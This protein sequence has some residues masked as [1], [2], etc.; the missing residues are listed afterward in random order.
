MSDSKTGTPLPAQAGE[1]PPMYPQQSHPQH[2]YPPQQPELY[3]Q[4]SYPQQPYPQQPYP[5]P[6]QQ[7]QPYP[8]QSYSSQQSY[9]PQQQYPSPPPQVYVQQPVILQPMS[10]NPGAGLFAQCAQ[11]MHT[12]RT[13][14]GIAGIIVAILCFPLGLICLF[15]D[16]RRKCDRCG[17]GLP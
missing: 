16:R 14:Y 15:V 6:H 13:D 8:Q 12:P 11:G 4:Q 1:Q 9:A 7:S 10:V 2:P 17:V 5:V 3:H